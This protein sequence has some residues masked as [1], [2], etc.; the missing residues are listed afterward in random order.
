M[1]ASLSSTTANL[2]GSKCTRG[3]IA[4]TRGQFLKMQLPLSELLSKPCWV[5]SIL[6]SVSSW[7]WMRP[8][9]RV[10]TR[11]AIREAHAPGARHQLMWRHV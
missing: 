6:E 9:H 8:I 11:A 10:P 7:P 2:W 4:A 5:A 3:C 1:T